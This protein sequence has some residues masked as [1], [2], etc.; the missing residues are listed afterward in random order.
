MQAHFC[1][2]EGPAS[3]SLQGTEA[4]GSSQVHTSCP[5]LSRCASRAGSSL[6]KA[7]PSLP[8]GQ[9]CGKVSSGPRAAARLPDQSQPARSTPP[10][11]FLFLVVPE[12]IGRHHSWLCFSFSFFFKSVFLLEASEG[13]VWSQFCRLR[14]PVPSLLHEDSNPGHSLRVV[15]RIKSDNVHG[16]PPHMETLFPS[17]MP[18]TG[19]GCG[20]RRP[21]LHGHLR[22][23]LGYIEPRSWSAMVFCDHLSPN[24]TCL[25]LSHS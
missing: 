11:S 21:G 13:G 18:R 6:S 15:L 14:F 23:V 2:P 19:S 9:G 17:E 1:G 22:P 24:I 10:F 4:T 12:G 20:L 5:A 16:N 7:A 25:F 8:A 3:A